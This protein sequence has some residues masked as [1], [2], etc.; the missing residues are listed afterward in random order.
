MIRPTLKTPPAAT[1]VTLVEAKEHA[2]VDFSEDDF[3]LQ[4]YVKAATAHLDGYSGIL[5][6][7]LV[8]QTWEQGYSCWSRRMR[9]PFPDIISAEVS[10]FD[11]D[12]VQ[13]TVSDSLYEVTEGARGGEIVFR[14]AF[15]RPGLDDD[16]DAPI[17]ITFVAGYGNPSDV[18]EDIKIAIEALARHWYDG[19]DGMPPHMVLLEKY[20]FVPV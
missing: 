7:C 10:Y 19:E 9:L 8:Q 3:M 16:R 6:R 14:D 13:Q 2:D 4:S 15:T 1:P 11:T 18:P 17:L 12:G 5:G 20:R